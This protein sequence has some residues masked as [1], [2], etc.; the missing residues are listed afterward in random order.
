MISILIYDEPKYTAKIL[1]FLAL[2]TQ[3]GCWRGEKCFRLLFYWSYFPIFMTLAPTWTIGEQWE[4][5]PTYPFLFFAPYLFN[6][7]KFPP[8]MEHPSSPS[9][10]TLPDTLGT[11]TG[12]SVSTFPIL[13]TLILLALLW[14]TT[15]LRRSFQWTMQLSKTN[16]LLRMPNGN[17]PKTV[18]NGHAHTPNSEIFLATAIRISVAILF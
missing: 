15:L 7:K 16:L 2:N 8:T 11:S 17:H 10:Y 9:S 14:T 18:S 1:Q 5:E 3:L 12:D 4:K 13:F 6:T